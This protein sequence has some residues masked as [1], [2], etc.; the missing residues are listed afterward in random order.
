MDDD[1][2]RGRAA[3]DDGETDGQRAA[4]DGATQTDRQQ[5]LMGRGREQQMMG[6]QTDRRTDSS[7]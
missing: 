4:N 5:Q 3:D 2:E 7:R 6:R 1:G